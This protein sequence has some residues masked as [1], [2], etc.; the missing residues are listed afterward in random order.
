MELMPKSV[1]GPRNSV[2]KSWTDSWKNSF[3]YSET[4]SKETMANF[5]QK[6]VI[7]KYNYFY[8]KLLDIIF[9]GV[10]YLYTS[11]KNRRDNP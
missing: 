1:A 10:W 4:N 9:R 6:T 3:I 5:Y 8:F 11:E 2:N 7:H